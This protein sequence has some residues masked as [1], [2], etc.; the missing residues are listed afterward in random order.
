MPLA[1][2]QL[3][4]G[5]AHSHWLHW[6]AGQRQDGPAH[7]GALG[8]LY[9]PP[10]P[11]TDAARWDLHSE[12]ELPQAEE[13][14]AGA[15][16]VSSLNPSCKR[17][18]QARTEGARV[19]VPQS[20][21]S[22][23]GPESASQLYTAPSSCLLAALP[24]NKFHPYPS[25]G[26]RGHPHCLP[27]HC[28]ELTLS[29]WARPVKMSTCTPCFLTPNSGTC[30]KRQVAALSWKQAGSQRLRGRAL[31]IFYQC[32]R[33]GQTGPRTLN[34]L[35]DTPV[36]SEALPS[37]CPPVPV[38]LGTLPQLAAPAGRNRDSRLKP[39][40]S[41]CV[42]AHTPP[43]SIW[44]EGGRKPSQPCSGLL[45]NCLYQSPLSP[46]PPPSHEGKRK[47]EEVVWAEQSSSGHWKA[48]VRVP[49]AGPLL[50]KGSTS[51]SLPGH[52]R[53]TLN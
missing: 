3:R 52:L 2:A 1:T 45:G 24:R 19:S 40:V 33:G 39:P 49:R 50:H 31:S 27:G 12:P 7:P 44:T 8:W 36:L 9:T 41:P 10:S 15:F 34:I 22:T 25:R 16:L 30:G 18:L 20:A 37:P 6:P 5:S 26:A 48:V 32:W 4:A 53:I 43:P 51:I 29:G 42:S 11:T 13:W 14:V 21:P 23:Q 28:L 35:L 46:H 38:R 17:S 47:K